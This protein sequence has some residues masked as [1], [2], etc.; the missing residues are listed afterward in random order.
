[1]SSSSISTLLVQR[2]ETALGVTLSAQGQLQSA[3]SRQLVLPTSSAARPEALES[4]TKARLQTGNFQ[5]MAQNVQATLGQRTALQGAQVGNANNTGSQQAIGQA[6]S[7][8]ADAAARPPLKS[9]STRWSNAAKSVLALL[10]HMPKQAAPLSN[11]N[12]APIIPKNPKELL[13]YLSRPADSAATGGAGLQTSGGASSGAAGAAGAQATSAGTPLK[14]EAIRA[15]GSSL[16]ASIIRETL[17]REITRP[18]LSYEATIWRLLRSNG[19]LKELANHPKALLLK[20]QQAEQQINRHI[21]L[22]PA[23]TQGKAEAAPPALSGPLAS[24]VQQQLEMHHQQR[25]VWQGEAWQ[26]AAMSWEIQKDNPQAFAAQ[27]PANRPEEEKN[28][29]GSEATHQDKGEAH[30]PWS[31]T[32]TLSLPQLGKIRIMV[33]IIDNHVQAQYQVIDNPKLKDNQSTTS[34]LLQHMPE[35]TRRLQAL[36]LETHSF[37]VFTDPSQ[38]QSVIEQKE[39]A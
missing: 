16:F 22:F 17:T 33:Q 15:L 2:L 21:S 8:A 23:L 36:G 4:A 32:L 13:S 1:M 12:Q 31:T 28:D 30:T 26:G 5:A 9:T 25:I 27:Q 11:P 10:E 24:L 7:N 6:G 34:L 18:G 35:F 29:A 37:E 3:R 38:S 14:E 20:E 19:N 39:E